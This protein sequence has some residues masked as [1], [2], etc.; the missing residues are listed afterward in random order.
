MLAVVQYFASLRILERPRSP[1]ERLTCFQE[2]DSCAADSSA[3]AAA[4]PASPP[5]TI[6][7]RGAALGGGAVTSRLIRFA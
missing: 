5:P 1:T 6:T 2:R 3:T 7:T 4:I